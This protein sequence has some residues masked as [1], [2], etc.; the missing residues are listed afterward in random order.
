MLILISFAE[1]ASRCPDIE[2][3]LLNSSQIGSEAFE[4]V[5]KC[6]SGGFQGQIFK[7][8]AQKLAHLVQSKCS[9]WNTFVHN[10]CE[11]LLNSIKGIKF[12]LPSKLLSDLTD[13]AERLLSDRDMHMHYVEMLRFCPVFW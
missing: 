8:F 12:L 3:I 6:P 10:V 7:D 2:D 1:A 9:E 4:R 11:V 5:R 13:C